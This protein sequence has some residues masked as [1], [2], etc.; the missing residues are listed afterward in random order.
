MKLFCR[1][2]SLCTILFALSPPL[3]YASDMAAVCP[4]SIK[5]NQTIISQPDEWRAIQDA[6][7][8]WLSEVKFFSGPP[9]QMMSLKYDEDNDF[10]GGYHL[11]WHFQPS[12]SGY[13]LACYYLHTTVALARPL[14]QQTT[15][16]K[17]T[18]SRAKRPHEIKEIT[19][20]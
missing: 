9:D 16:C 6:V 17:V 20:R 3:S 1:S 19:C 8:Q 15:E 13:W 14:P 12:K 11:I 5:T 4:T 10:K 7:P 2:F 18:Y